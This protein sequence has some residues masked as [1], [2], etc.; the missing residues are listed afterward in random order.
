MDSCF[1]LKSNI[2][3][4]DLQEKPACQVCCWCF[5][6]LYHE[7]I[8]RFFRYRE[9]TSGAQLE[10]DLVDDN[11]VT[12]KSDLTTTTVEQTNAAL[13][14]NE[15]L[16]ETDVVAAREESKGQHEGEDEGFS[17]TLGQNVEGRIQNT[18][19]EL[20]KN[21]EHSVEIKLDKDDSTADVD[22]SEKEG[23][24]NN[25]C[26]SIVTSIATSIVTRLKKPEKKPVKVTTWLSCPVCCEKVTSR[27]LLLKHM[28]LH[29]VWVLRTEKGVATEGVQGVF[30]ALNLRMPNIPQGLTDRE[31][32]LAIED[33]LIQKTA[34]GVAIPQPEEHFNTS[35]PVSFTQPTDQN[36]GITLENTFIQD[37]LQKET[38]LNTIDQSIIRDLVQ[39]EPKE[40][41]KFA[42]T[43]DRATIYKTVQKIVQ[44]IK[45]KQLIGGAEGDEE[46]TEDIPKKDDNNK[47]QEKNEISYLCPFCVKVH[48]SLIDCYKHVTSAHNMVAAFQC[49]RKGCRQVFGHVHDYEKHAESHRQ[50]AFVCRVCNFH[51]EEMLDAVSHKSSAHRSLHQ[52]EINR[53]D[54][55][56][57]TF[58]TK[59][60]LTKHVAMDKHHHQCDQCGK[61]RTGKNKLLKC[62]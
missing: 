60:A 23:E 14:G 33:V 59:E 6:I 50:A 21:G 32:G 18:E 52:T 20:N 35:A 7:D 11:E 41:D 5:T 9:E 22:L 45:I 12:N 54:L 19:I 61:V 24:Q 3:V 48:K 46:E 42:I 8:Y 25:A 49:I 62:L 36:G 38:G 2:K 53:C 4:Y 44:D 10:H 15:A 1:C 27:A 57:R 17:E 26:S 55:C 58:A 29:R 37:A 28:Q 47:D 30:D 34:H 13:E 51:F 56:N 39:E 40:T 43:L 16:I 31:T